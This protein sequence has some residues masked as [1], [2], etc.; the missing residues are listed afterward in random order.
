MGGSAHEGQIDPRSTPDP[1]RS[2]VEVRT[3]PRIPP[4]YLP[5][6][7]QIHPRSAKIYRKSIENLSNP[8]CQTHL[9]S[10]PD[11]PQIHPASVKINIVLVGFSI[12][13]PPI[14]SHFFAVSLWR[15][16]PSLLVAL[17]RCPLARRCC[18]FWLLVA[19][20]LSRSLDARKRSADFK[21]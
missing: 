9:G 3:K 7:P 16:R 17:V 8:P 15:H 20:G 11:R 19:G 2:T 6:P 21:A 4:R 5:D 14:H 13:A 10:T 18:L 12:D 1:P